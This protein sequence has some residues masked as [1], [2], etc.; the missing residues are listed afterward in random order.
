MT[1]TGLLCSKFGIPE[2]I[3]LSDSKAFNDYK[4][5]LT[6]NYVCFALNASG[7]KHYYWESNGHAEVDFIIQYKEGNIIPIEVK[8]ANNVRAKSLQQFI[9][10]INQYT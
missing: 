6:E 2:N 4:G 8:A 9:K 10:N 5:A 1:D 7:Y 3:I